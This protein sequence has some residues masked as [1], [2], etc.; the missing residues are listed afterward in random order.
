MDEYQLANI[1]AYMSMVNHYYFT[2]C[3]IGFDI[4]S[5]HAWRDVEMGNVY[6]S[7]GNPEEF[8]NDSPWF[9]TSNSNATNISV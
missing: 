8:H 2:V 7:T 1:F 3:H 6:R 9:S 5:I 4:Y